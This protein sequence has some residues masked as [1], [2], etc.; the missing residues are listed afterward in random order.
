MTLRLFVPFDLAAGPL[1]LG[2][3]QSHYVANV[4]RAKPGEAVTLFNG[5]DGE[6]CGTLETVAKSAVVVALTSQTRPQT[7]EPD[8]WLLAAPIKKDCIDLVAEKATELGASRLWPV[9]TRR[10]VTARVNTE[11]LAAHMVEAA[12]QCERLTVPE[13]MEPQPLDKVLA[14]WDAA[15]PLIFLD[16]SGGGMPL[17]Q[18]LAD[19]SSGPLAVLVGPEGG[20]APEERAVLA[21]L[22]FARP[23]GLG[24]RILRAETAAIAALS[25]IQAVRGDWNRAPRG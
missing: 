10:T 19:L 18:V 14:G 21:R 4:M 23:V 20:F 13:V 17:V 3:E 12:E 9:I 25:V 16:E 6:W 7:A 15:R 11:R 5:R 1:T 22:P 8:L 2:K 24:P